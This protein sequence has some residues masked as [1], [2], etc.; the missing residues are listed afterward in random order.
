M[1]NALQL[2]PCRSTEEMRLGRLS[3]VVSE[4]ESLRRVSVYSEYEQKFESITFPVRMS[5]CYLHNRSWRFN[6]Q[7]CFIT[8]IFDGYLR[9]KAYHWYPVH[10]IG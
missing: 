5:S 4:G 7:L 6:S 2:D 10:T 1:G 3:I 8:Y 9:D